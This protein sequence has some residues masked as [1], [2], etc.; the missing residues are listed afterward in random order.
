MWFPKYICTLTYYYTYTF[1]VYFY[2]RLR[3]R[4]FLPLYVSVGFGQLM[5]VT[6]R[7]IEEDCVRH[8]SFCT[9]DADE[10][11][12]LS[13]TKYFDDTGTLESFYEYGCLSFPSGCPIDVFAR[14]F[15][16]V[17]RSRAFNCCRNE[18]FCNENLTVSV[19]VPTSP[20]RVSTSPP[21]GASTQTLGEFGSV[22]NLIN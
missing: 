5:C 21:V 1:F 9:C 6:N 12:F 16:G 2:V 11:C 15:N 19:E 8:N 14:P 3:P 7:V 18:D 4:V 22:Y 17:L 20:S 10:D 13:I